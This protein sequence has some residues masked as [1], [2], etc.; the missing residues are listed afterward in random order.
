VTLAQIVTQL[1]A[2]GGGVYARDV[3]ADRDV[4][5]GAMGGW[6]LEGADKE[7]F[8]AADAQGGTCAEGGTAP[9]VAFLSGTPTYA[10][11]L[12]DDS[13]LDATLYRDAVPGRPIA[14]HHEHADFNGRQYGADSAGFVRETGGWGCGCSGRGACAGCEMAGC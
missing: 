6:V 13:S 3:T 10:L 12:Q 1:G 5:R 9:S 7:A 4:I 8:E 2:G 11:W 14:E